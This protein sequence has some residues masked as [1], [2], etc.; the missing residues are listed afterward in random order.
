[1]VVMKLV[2]NESSEKRRSKQLFPTPAQ[3]QRRDD[4][5]GPKNCLAENTARRVTQT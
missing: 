1:M 2:V 5:T 3:S 4:V